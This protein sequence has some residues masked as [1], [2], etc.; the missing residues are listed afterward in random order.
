MFYSDNVPVEYAQNVGQY[1]VD[2]DLVLDHQQSIKLTSN[3]NTFIL[4]MILDSKYDQLPKEM[5]RDL[6]LLESDIKSVVFNNAN[7]EIEICDVNFYP[8]NLKH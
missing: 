8:L 6:M 5:E 1:F 4:K 2:H 3:H 7:F